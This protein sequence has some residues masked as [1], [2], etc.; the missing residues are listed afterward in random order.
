M[1]ALN[2]LLDQRP[3]LNILEDQRPK[4]IFWR[5]G[6]QNTWRSYQNNAESG[7]STVKRPYIDTLVSENGV[8]L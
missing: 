8:F 5:A 3:K 6:D 2:I 7:T 4:I 1:P